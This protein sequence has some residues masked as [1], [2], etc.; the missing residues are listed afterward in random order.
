LVELPRSGIRDPPSR[1][2]VGD[3]YRR[4]ARSRIIRYGLISDV[5]GNLEA[6]TAVLARLNACGVE[7]L[8]CLGDLVG[9]GADPGPCLERVRQEARAVVQGNHDAGVVG[10]LDLHWFNP[11]ARA[12]ARWTAG[13]LDQEQQAYLSALPLV[14]EID[15]ATLVHA[16]P[17]VPEEWDYLSSAQDGFEAFPFFRTRLCFVGHS[18]RP[19]VWIEGADGPRFEPN[20]SRQ[21]LLPGHRYIVNVGSVGQPRDRDPRAAYAIWDTGTQT[22]EVCRVP[23]DTSGAQAK[24]RNAGLPP[25][26]ADRLTHGV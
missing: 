18:H 13:R 14:T 4:G 2:N 1:N 24:I 15:G 12:A 9:Y 20:P 16:S 22:I 3:A 10:L 23:Y 11:F 21:R 25:V 7:A 8:L 17:R 19:G 5:H 26:L 6:L